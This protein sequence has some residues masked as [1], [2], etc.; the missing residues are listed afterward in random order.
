MSGL[1][2]NLLNAAKSLTAQQTGVEVAGRNLAN[3]NTPAYARQRV[4]LGDRLTFEGQFGP[5]GNGVEVLGIKQ[6]RDQFLDVAVT[7]EGAQTGLLQAQQSGLDRAEAALGEHVDRSGDSASISATSNSTTGIAAGLN[8]FFNAF[9]ELA[10]NPTDA[11][12]K[13]VLLQK[14]DILANK[15]NVTDQRLS[16]LQDDLTEEVAGGTD[17]VNSLLSQ[18]ADLNG[19]IMKF[20]IQRPG[21][22]LELRDQRQARLEELSKYM[23]FSA[24]SIPGANGQIQI[25][26]KDTAGADVVL[27]DKTSVLGG[28]SFDGTQISGGAPST[29]LG[30]QGGALKGQLL[31]RDGT[32]Q[33]LRDDIKRTADQ[34]TTGVN[35]AY[36]ATGANF[37]QTPPGSGLL[38]LDPS[39]SFSTL[40]AS[41]TGDAGANEVALAVADVART[42]YS[43]G[44]GA[45][46]DGTIGGFFT[47]TVSGLGEALRGI[48]DKVSD[49]ELIERMTITNRDSVS[50]VS[51]DEEMTDLMKFQRSY[52]ASARVVRV[53]DEMLDGLINNM[54]R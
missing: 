36:G 48:D 1:I 30:L 26:A 27:V 10:A 25:V 20:E 23:D 14:A 32:I 11:G 12:A 9:E 8:D 40:K 18:V 6:I 47:K 33:Q 31:V 29:P 4:K 35:A 49:Q 17:K 46:I 54:L 52:Q 53:M 16:S 37:F 38:A 13:Q 24:R 50:A 41:A 7:R 3:L 22:A 34:L 5:V 39:L 28:I 42:T 44:A 51:M 15:F 19:E 45:T 2:G 43:T 21:S